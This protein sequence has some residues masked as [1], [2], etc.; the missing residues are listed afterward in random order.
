MKIVQPS[1]TGGEISPAL[2]ARV[3][4]ARYATSLKTCRNFIVSSY[5]GVYNRPGQR[6]IAATQLSGTSI[7]RLIPFQFNIE[8]NYLV[9]LGAGYARFFANGAP[10]LNAG[11][12]VQ[13]NTPWTVDEI[14]DVKYTQSADVMYLTHPFHPVN[15]ITR[16]SANAFTISVYDPAEGPFLPVNSD[17]S[18]KVASSGITGNVT[19]TCNAPGT[20]AANMVGMLIYLENR[21]LSTIRPWTSGEKNVGTGTYRRNAGKTYQ[22]TAISTGG[23]YRLTGGNAPTHDQGT[24]WDGPGDVR[25]DGTDTYSV[26][27]AWT[28]IDSGYG[29]A[30]IT[31]FVSDTA[32]QALVTKQMPQGVVGGTGSPGGTWNLTGTGSTLT[33]PLAGNVSSDVALYSVTIDGTPTQSNPN[34]QP[35]PGGPVSNCVAVDMA[36]PGGFTAGEADGQFV[37]CVDHRTLEVFEQQAT[38]FA[39]E[40]EPCWRA[41]TESGA[42]VVFSHGTRC[43]TL[44]R[45]YVFGDELEGL[46]L[47]VS[48]DD[49]VA[50]WET[51][52]SVTDAGIRPVAKIGTGDHNYLAGGERGR[53]VSTHNMIPAKD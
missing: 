32:I 5:G 30:K 31:G 3:D 1:F 25:N 13:V 6:F 47:P 15:K 11:V 14:W 50:V 33:F 36:M 10:V 12:P 51:V 48:G 22:C 46:S 35:N 9:E 40:P 26:G 23:T 16:V 27:V 44:E 17:E 38:V 29:I 24:Q 52:V 7:S 41:E 53:Y 39:I 18:V 4:L 37:Q 28:Y 2:Y 49:L 21:N 45:G 42:W 43:E 20:F 19:I 8:Q 34:Y